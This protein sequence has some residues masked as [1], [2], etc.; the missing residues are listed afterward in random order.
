MKKYFIYLTFLTFTISLSAADRNIGIGILLG[1]PSSMVLKYKL[2]SNHYISGGIG[3]APFT[4]SGIVIHADYLHRDFD[5]FPQ[6]QYMN[7]YYGFG[8]RLSD[9][10]KGLGVGARGV[11]GAFL[12]HRTIPLEVFFETAPVFRLFPDTELGLDFGVGIHYFF[13]SSGF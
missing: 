11:V 9:E 2:E 13:D 8:V 4:D 6:L 3:Y 7:F 12:K 1:N 5:L 10:E